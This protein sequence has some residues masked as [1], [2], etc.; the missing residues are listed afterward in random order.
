MMELNDAYF[1][2][3][4]PLFSR[5]GDDPS[6]AGPTMSSAGQLG[7]HVERHTSPSPMTRDSGIQVRHSNSVN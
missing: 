3:S 1:F 6:L 7:C 4:I 5:R 2:F